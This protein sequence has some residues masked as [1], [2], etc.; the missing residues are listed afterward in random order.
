L[1]IEDRHIARRSSGT[2]AEDQQGPPGPVEPVLARVDPV[3]ATPIPLMS[4]PLAQLIDFV[5]D[6]LLDRRAAPAQLRRLIPR[7]VPSGFPLL[8]FQ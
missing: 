4:E 3:L 7:S 2:L 5:R 1:K 6:G 8:D